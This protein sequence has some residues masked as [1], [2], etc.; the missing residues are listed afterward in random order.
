MVRSPLGD[1]DFDEEN[2]LG[3]AALMQPSPED[4][5]ADWIE[6]SVFAKNR[7]GLTLQLCHYSQAGEVGI[8]EWLWPD[9]LDQQEASSI[10]TMIYTHANEDAENHD[11]PASRY[12]IN[13]LD[14]T[15][16]RVSRVLFR[17]ARE[18]MDPSRMPGGESEVPHTAEGHVAQ[19][20]RHNEQLM[21]MNLAMQLSTARQNLMLHQ[22]LGATRTQLHKQQIEAVELF[23]NMKDREILRKI[24]YGKHQR[25]EM[26]KDAALGLVMKFAPHVAQRIGLMTDDE[27]AQ[28]QTTDAVS[29]WLAAMPE[30]E[31]RRMIAGTADP[32]KR[33]AFERAWIMAKKRAAARAAKSALSGAAQP[34]QLQGSNTNA[35]AAKTPE[36]S[37][38]IQF[39]A[40]ESGPLNKTTLVVLNLLI[41]VDD[42]IFA[43]VMPRIPP[44]AHVEIKS[45]R[46]RVRAEGHTALSAD[47][48]RA[49]VMSQRPHVITMLKTASDQDIMLLLTQISNAAHKL[50][51]QQAHKIVRDK[52][53]A[54]AA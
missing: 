25:T 17:I 15:G 32:A 30:D 41:E 3:D 52:V 35:A 39:T 1:P 44:E 49:A 20:Y 7:P 47:E 26:V 31:A 29:D 45:I 19:A 28:L 8:H 4:R 2:P 48:W 16:R 51:V 54:A 37:S 53:K 21:R 22:E 36:A 11:S 50:I 46:E 13:L 42:T 33:N 38:E 34:P 18:D 12:S 43:M 10:A 40:E 5:I 23:Q 14:K 27:A 6:A 24:M 9:D